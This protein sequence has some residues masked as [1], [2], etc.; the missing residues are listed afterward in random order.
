MIEVMEMTLEATEVILGEEDVAVLRIEAV[1]DVVKDLIKEVVVA[2]LTMEVKEAGVD[3]EVILIMEVRGHQ[4]SV[5]EADHSK[6]SK[7]CVMYFSNCYL[8]SKFFFYSIITL[9]KC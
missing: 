6:L 7:L 5:V 4:D 9:F 3:V 1:E 8:V 2:D